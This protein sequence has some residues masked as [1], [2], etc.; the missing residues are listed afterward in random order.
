MRREWEQ[1]SFLSE[2]KERP[3]VQAFVK[4]IIEYVS[5]ERV[6]PKYETSLE[7]LCLK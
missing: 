1:A 7:T 2:I 4:S 3:E 5:S 6:E